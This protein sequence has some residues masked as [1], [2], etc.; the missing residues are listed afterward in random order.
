MPDADDFWDRYDGKVI[1]V[2]A[3][4]R[5]VADLENELEDVKADRARWIQT[6]EG[7]KNKLSSVRGLADKLRETV[8]ASAATRL[9]QMDRENLRARGVIGLMLVALVDA[10]SEDDLAWRASTRGGGKLLTSITDGNLDAVPED[11]L[12]SREWLEQLDMDA[13]RR[14]LSLTE[15]DE[16]EQA[17]RPTQEAIYGEIVADEPITPPAG[18]RVNLPAIMGPFPA[19]HVTIVGKPSFPPPTAE[20]IETL[21]NEVDRKPKSQPEPAAQAAGRNDKDTPLPPPP[22]SATLERNQP[23]P[24]LISTPTRD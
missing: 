8:P 6:C 12:V 19:S 13:L 7:L 21:V 9:A 3:L 1:E 17:A 11:G 24:P 14:E 16:P 20:S 15:L 2:Q 18:A 10:W 23:P 4:R 5:R 22:P